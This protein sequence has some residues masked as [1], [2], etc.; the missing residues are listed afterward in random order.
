[1]S[2]YTYAG[3]FVLELVSPVRTIG[4]VTTQP[5]FIH[6]LGDAKWRPEVTSRLER[7][8]VELDPASHHYCQR[9]A[10]TRSAGS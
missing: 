5:G 7:C 2:S 8:T 1:M 3:V 9:A 4:V 10:Q 6:L